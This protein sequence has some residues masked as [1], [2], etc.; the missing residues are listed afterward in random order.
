LPGLLFNPFTFF[1]QAYLAVDFLEA[2]MNR[3]RVTLLTLIGLQLLAILACGGITI[4]PHATGEPSS[5]AAAS[6]VVDR[7][8]KIPASA[9]KYSPATDSAPPLVTGGEYEKPVPVPGKVNTAGGEDSPFI[10]PDGNTLYFFFTPDVTVPVEKQIQ[11]GVTGIY[12]STKVNGEW[13][14]P[15]RVVLQDK[16]KL[17]LDGC[18]FVLGERMW[19][20]ST[21]EGYEGVNWFTAD[22]RNGKW[23]NVQIADFN[24][25][26][27][28]GELHITAD[29]NELYFASDR[30]GGKG[31]LD[32]WVSNKVDG[33]WQE[34]A[35]VANVN[36]ADSEGW[37]AIS[38]DGNELW[39]TRNYGIWRSVKVNG[40]WQTPEQIVSPLAGEATVD[41]TGNLYFVHHFYNGEKMVEADIYVAYKK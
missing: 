22:Y 9:V 6:A 39:I 32:I 28:V 19:F 12:V 8:A 20:C 34:P 35:N 5:T 33:A 1:N 16:M 30:P 18:E 37:P 4:T 26:Y 25:E 10:L 7:Q 31:K 36:T 41:E 40:E 2:R 23:Q 21:R 15:E 29:G 11:D 24:P 3:Q 13:G 27:K 17:A 38:P 14:E